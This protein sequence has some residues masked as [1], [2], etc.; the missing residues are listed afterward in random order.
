MSKTFQTV[1]KPT[2]NHKQGWLMLG[3]VLGVA[4]L[5]G[6]V[7]LPKISPGGDASA[8][9]GQP[10]PDFA[11]PVIFNGD[12]GNRVRLADLRGKA[13]V[14]DFWASW[15][16]P[17]RQE[18]PILDAV[19][20]HLRGKGVVFVGIN[21]G[22]RRENAIA[23]AKSRDLSYTEAFDDDGRVAEDYGVQAL[24]TLVVIDRQGRIVAMLTRLVPK[25]EVEAL[26]AKALSG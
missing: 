2:T 5:F 4:V 14:L 8:V 26:V 20:R 9:S 17:C 21:T 12:S 19:A 7:V 22:D 24:P 10:A 3:V 1:H 15:C 16:E 11:L 18:A 23:F 25:N 6:A 13:V